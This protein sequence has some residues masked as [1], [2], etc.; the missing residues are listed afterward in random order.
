MKKKKISETIN[1][2]NF[3]YIDEATQYKG[4]IKNH[5]PKIWYKWAAVAACIALVLAIGFPFAKDLFISS[6]YKD[7]ADTVML[8]EYDN[9][10]LEIIE[11]PKNNEKFGVKNEITEA[12]IGKHLVYLQKEFPEAERSNY[13][14][15]NKETNI[16]LL[17]YA[18]APY[19]AVQIFRDGDKYYY[20]WF[21]NYLIKT[22]ESLPIQKAFEVY[23]IDDA[24]DIVSITP[25]K[26]DNTWITNDKAITD[27]AIISE[28]YNEIFVLTAFSFDDYH[29]FM[30][31]D[32]LKELEQ[33]GNNIDSEA[34]TRV[35][36]DRKD[37][38]IET[39][40]GLRFMMHYYPSYSWINVTTTMSYYQMS[41]EITKWFKNNIK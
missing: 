5:F 30:F 10:Y 11:E 12:V 41:P 9:A 19:K 20:A 29:D 17:E 40:D 34:Y 6:D 37:I 2:I 33:I 38:I 1:N 4:A 28:F 18:P 26:N 27:S 23:G 24:S 7:I 31:A 39:T 16:E 32:E 35:A 36:D 14:V 8:I 15:A 25:T 21:C 22:N 3:N 13:I